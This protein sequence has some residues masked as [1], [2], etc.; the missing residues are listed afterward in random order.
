M[1][2]IRGGHVEPDVPLSA[3][4]DRQNGRYRVDIYVRTL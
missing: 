3:A 1:A 4:P 2:A